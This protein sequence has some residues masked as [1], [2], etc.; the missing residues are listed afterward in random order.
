MAKHAATYGGLADV[1]TASLGDEESELH[2]GCARMTELTGRLTH[3]A[4]TAGALR[5]EVTGDDLITLISAAAWAREQLS[6][7]RSERLIRFTLE[8]LRS[9]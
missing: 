5:P 7:A 4:R 2:A 8:G 3:A 9:G 1:L 6:A